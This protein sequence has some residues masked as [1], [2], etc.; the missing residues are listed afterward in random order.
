[1]LRE[2]LSAAREVLLT[3]GMFCVA[4]VVLE[5][6][7]FFALLYDARYAA[8]GPIAQLLAAQVW[9]ALLSLTLERAL[10]AVGD[11]RS[12]AAYNGV[13]FVCSAVAA[14]LGFYL[15]DLPGFIVGCSVGGI[16]GHLILMRR[17]AGHGIG[18]WRDDLRMSATAGLAVI[19]GLSLVQTAE[20]AG[21]PVLR[22]VAAWTYLAVLAVQPLRSIRELRQSRP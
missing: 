16:A 2:R 13:K 17:L 3:F 4:A 20:S 21:G 1:L 18:V 9:V 19:L 14:G 5:A 11:T 22:E 15:G 6:G 10:Q 8:A 12:L 7:T